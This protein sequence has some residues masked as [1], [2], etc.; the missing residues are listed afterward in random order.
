VT[1]NRLKIALFIAVLAAL[2]LAA[3]VEGTGPID[4]ALLGTL[5]AGHRPLLADVARILTL[6]GG[7]YIVTPLI[8]IVAVLLAWRK[9]TWLALVLFA[10]NSVGRLLVELQKYE[11][12]RVRP[13]VNP[14]LV[15]VYTLSFPS[16]HSANAMM[17]Y[18]AMALMLPRA[19]DARVRWT[20]AAAIL[21]FLIGLSRVVLGVHWPSDVLAGWSFG[22][23][24]VLV[25]LWF[26]KRA[27]TPV[28]LE[29]GTQ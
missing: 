25:M 7:G 10:G 29:G 22:A 8:V 17:T 19:P 4:R 9:R 16:A 1:S 21:A 24:W 11:M 12:G 15:T 28:R 18:V 6:V 14:H 26:A 27:A 20:I 23:L 13:D 5:Y 2:W 3:F